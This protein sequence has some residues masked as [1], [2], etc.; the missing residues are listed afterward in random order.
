MSDSDQKGIVKRTLSR[1]KFNM[2][3][4]GSVLLAACGDNG[5]TAQPAATTTAAPATT[6]EAAPATTTPATT[7]T[8]AAT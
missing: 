6:T 4:G 5:D 1:R 3:A 8:I 2:I 7:T